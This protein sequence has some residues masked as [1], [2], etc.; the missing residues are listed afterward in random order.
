MEHSP[1]RVGPGPGRVFLAVAALFWGASGAWGQNPV[2][3]TNPL[4]ALTLS[5]YE[6]TEADA[7]TTITVTAKRMTGTAPATA[8]TV[9]LSLGGTATENTD[10][11]ATSIS[12]LSIPAN[13]DTGTTT[14]TINPTEDTTAESPDETIA[15]TAS[16]TG[17]RFKYD[18]TIIL[19]EKPFVSFPKMIEAHAV[20][21][22]TPITD[23][24]VDDAINATG[25]ATYSADASPTTDYGLSFNTS[26]RVISG[27]LNSAATGGTVIKYTV[28]ATDGTTN[29]TATTKVSIF[30]VD[31]VCTAKSG[32]VPS[33]I[34]TPSADLIRDCNILMEAKDD[35]PGAKTGST[36]WSLDHDIQNWQGNE[37][38]RMQN[39]ATRIQEIKFS[40]GG[41]ALTGTSNQLPPVL[42]TL[43]ALQDLWIAGTPLGHN[44]TG[45]IPPEYGSLTNLQVLWI[46][47]QNFTGKTIPAELGD[48]SKLGTLRLQENK[49]TGTIPAE[50]GN[51]S[52]LNDLN[53]SEN[54]LSG[55]IPPNWVA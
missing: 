3:L 14:I 16:G 17:V 33:R 1:G 23:I 2:N 31:D 18:S 43:D 24:V 39:T 40:V 11:T 22:G 9:I 45:E 13:G 52:N 7:A 4:Y 5:Q 35:L 44:V 6:L 15:I 36:N 47:S 34:S 26:T 30:V 27:T 32:W 42:G 20:Y 29:K 50:L 54:R 37:S 28:T 41:T 38:F 55:S 19:K 10:Y 25:T 46:H 51:L 53:L 8:T 49:L 48:L 12:T 21:A